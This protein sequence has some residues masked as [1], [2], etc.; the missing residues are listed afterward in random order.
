MDCQS[1]K[2]YIFSK[3][4][5]TSQKYATHAPRKKNEVFP[6]K[7]EEEEGKKVVSNEFS[8]PVLGAIDVTVDFQNF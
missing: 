7:K 4:K 5:V 3:S 6:L 1:D 8:Q 2:M